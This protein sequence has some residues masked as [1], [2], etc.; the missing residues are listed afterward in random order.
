MHIN[1][2]YD[3]TN[4]C[5]VQGVLF[6]PSALPDILDNIFSEPP[7]PPTK[8]FDD[9]FFVGTRFVGVLIIKTTN[10]LIMI[11]SMNYDADAYNVIIPGMQELRLNPEDI[12]IIVIT[13]GH[14]DHYGTAKLF[15][16]KYGCKV[17]MTKRDHQ[18]MLDVIIPLGDDRIKQGKDADPG[19]DLYLND[20][21]QIV[22]GDTKVEVV[23][24][25]GHTPGGISLII[26]VHDG[27]D[28]HYVGLWGGTKIPDNKQE[29]EEYLR[30]SEYFMQ[31]CTNAG[32][33][34]SVQIHPFVDY[35]L[36]KGIFTGRLAERK[37]GD[38]HPLVI[39]EKRFRIFIECIR[40][41]AAGKIEMLE[42]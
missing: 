27:S 16:E 14:L 39:G 38:L 34:V 32:V 8:L 26:P 25:P 22:C 19:I 12:K 15:K 37:K 17:A 18:F 33:D 5:D 42:K 29:A 3:A 30:S 10:G 2:S 9:L 24:T 21:D 1:R 35:N 40:V 11:D 31:K 36:K 20:G 28:K 23:F 6:I 13:H 41:A 7:L 4:G